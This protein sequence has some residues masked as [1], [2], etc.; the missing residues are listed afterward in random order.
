[1]PPSISDAWI[2]PRSSRGWG[3]SARR[4]SRSP[5]PVIGPACAIAS[6]PGGTRPVRRATANLDLDPDESTVSDRDL[7]LGGLG[8]DRGVRA[9]VAE[10]FPHPDAGVLLVRNRRHDHVAGEPERSRVT[11]R[12]ERRGDAALHVVGA[13]AVQP[14]TVNAGVERLGHPRHAD[15]V[16]VP[17]EQQCPATA[18]APCAD[19]DAGPPGVFC[20][21]L[22]LQA[23]R[24]AP[25]RDRLRNRALPALPRTRSGF[26]ESIET[27][28]ASRRPVRPACRYPPSSQS[29]R[30]GTSYWAR[31]CGPRRRGLIR[32]RVIACPR[33][34]TFAA[35]HL[36]RGT[37]RFAGIRD[38]PSD[39]GSWSRSRSPSSCSPISRSTTAWREGWPPRRRSAASSPS[40]PPPGCGCAGSSSAP[41]WPAS[42]PRSACSPARRCRRRSSAWRWWRRSAAMRS[43]SRC[44]WRSPGCLS[45][46]PS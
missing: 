29:S 31:G 44:G 16:D 11:A 32:D 35:S 8:D 17:A 13:T 18:R 22:D 21:R 40:T 23:G 46:S 7:E 28:S 38:R 27:R 20:E 34:G 45:C 10:D 3:R 43:R 1:M 25:L 26:T 9:D 24:G 2:E 30:P 36:R 19:H 42:W 15:G 6:T 37:G 33:D 41:R 14:V 5:M 4:E 39:G 12:E